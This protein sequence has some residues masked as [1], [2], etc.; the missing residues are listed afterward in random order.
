MEILGDDQE[1]CFRLQ[2]TRET[3]WGYYYVP[4]GLELLLIS[5]V[6][7]LPVGMAAWIFHDGLGRADI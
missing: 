4:S 1:A 3:L 6:C 5:I 2:L 7:V